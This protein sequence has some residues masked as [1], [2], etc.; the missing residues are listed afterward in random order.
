MPRKPYFLQG[1]GC[2]V[3]VPH[4]PQPH[5]GEG[6]WEEEAGARLAGRLCS[7]LSLYNQSQVCM[8]RTDVRA[9]LWVLCGCPHVPVMVCLTGVSSSAGACSRLPSACHYIWSHRGM[10]LSYLFLSVSHPLPRPTVTLCCLPLSPFSSVWVPFSCST[11]P[12]SC[13]SCTLPSRACT[14]PAHWPLLASLHPFSSS[15]HCPRL[16][17]RKHPGPFSGPS[18]LR[19]LAYLDTRGQT[20]ASLNL[21][22]LPNN[23][24][25]AASL[26]PLNS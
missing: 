4:P 17:C 10:C 8:L 13:F 12:W 24:R 1:C 22:Q 11:L 5:P 15:C 2:S 23:S 9:A 7:V 25:L 14:A 19:A 3:P 16:P 21:F 18:C 26:C 20:S 6:P